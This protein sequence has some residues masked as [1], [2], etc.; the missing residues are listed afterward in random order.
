MASQPEPGEEFET[1]A[2]EAMR[3]EHEHQLAEVLDHVIGVLVAA[4]NARDARA[5][6]TDAAAGTGPRAD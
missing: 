1:S 5:A 4:R 6:A 3:V 2:L